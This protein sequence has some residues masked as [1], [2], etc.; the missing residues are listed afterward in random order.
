VTSAEFHTANTIKSTGNYRTRFA[1]PPPS[2]QPYRAIVF[3]MFA[4]G[5]DTFNMLTPYSCTKGKDV[6]SEYRNVRQKVAL[7]K[8]NLLQIPSSNQVCETFGVH[9]SLKTVR[10]L[11]LDGDLSFFANTGVKTAPV[12]KTNYYTI[13]KTHPGQL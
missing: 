1:F 11:Y 12:N 13:T 9:S 5:C 6:Y 8:L 10:Q 7:F 4:G 3:I 2:S